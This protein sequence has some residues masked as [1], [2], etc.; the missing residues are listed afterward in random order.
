MDSSL[1]LKSIELELIFKL[2]RKLAKIE[3][4][5]TSKPGIV[6]AA[7]DF[8]VV[9]K[10]TL[11]KYKLNTF[12]N[13]IIQKGLFV[14]GSVDFQS[15]DFDEIV[16]NKFPSHLLCFSD[17]PF[18]D[19]GTK[20]KTYL[21]KGYKYKLHKRYKMTVRDR[22]CCSYCKSF[23]WFFFLKCPFVSKDSKTVLK[24]CY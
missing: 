12:A 4:Y 1:F 15:E 13:P 19:F 6:T 2:K 14:N 8:F 9:D 17:K 23:R 16:N 24:F 21:S 10:E 5:C 20:V 22:W 18:N 3:D 7:N 11:N